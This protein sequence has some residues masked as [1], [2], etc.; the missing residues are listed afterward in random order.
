MNLSTEKGCVSMA[1]KKPRGDTQERILTYIQE[2]IRMRG[3]APSVREI[4][5]AVGLK[6]T[7]TVHGHLMRLEKKGLL[8]RDAMKPRAMGI[9]KAPRLAEESLI[10]QLP[11][12]GRVAAG[13]PILAEENVEEYVSLP[14][15][16]AGEGEHFV[17]RV[18]GDSM[19]QAGIYHD[20]YIVVRKQQ[21]ANNGEIV[22]ALV[23]DEATV[24]RFF[25]ENGHFRLQPENDAME[26]IIV[27]SVTILGKVTSLLRKM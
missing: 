19:I 15:E 1:G 22:V 9:A 4:G 25:K 27:T 16:F 18:R 20:D 24:K 14:I 12:V 13:Q 17:L 23:E 21:H 2:E 26:P 6:S 5:E 8:H 10:C 7:S 3:Y 11:I